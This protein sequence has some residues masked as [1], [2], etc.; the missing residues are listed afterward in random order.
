MTPDRFAFAELEPDIVELVLRRV[1]AMAPGFSEA[2]ASQIER[3]VKAEHGGKRMFVPKGSKRLTFE[4]REALFKDG[5][6]NMSTEELTKKHKIS[7]A[8][9]YHAM[10]QGGRFDS[11]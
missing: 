11:N 7:R 3:E 9:M 10:K 4:Q 8:T 1:I 6:T 2:L 5:L